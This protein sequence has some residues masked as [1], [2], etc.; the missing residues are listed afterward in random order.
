MDVGSYLNKLL[1]N[2]TIN[3]QLVKHFKSVETILS[4][5]ACEI[6]E[7]LAFDFNLIEVS[8]SVC[9]AICSRAFI[10]NAIEESSIGKLSPRAYTPYDSSTPPQPL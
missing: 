10:P 6:I 9:L 2:D 8:N 3:Q 4:H 1:V 5:P 7:Q